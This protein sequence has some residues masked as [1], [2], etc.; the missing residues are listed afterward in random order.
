MNSHIYDSNRP[1]VY[2]SSRG[3]VANARKVVPIW[4]NQ[5][6][7]FDI[8]IAVEP[9]EFYLYA[10]GL[11]ECGINYAEILP[12][13]RPN[14][15]LAYSRKFCVTHAASFGWESIIA[16]DD[17]IKPVHGV[18]NTV[19]DAAHPKA[20]GI[21]IR[22]SYHDLAL[23]DKIRSLGGIILQPNGMFRMVALNV[24]NVMRLGNYDPNA[25]NC[26]DADLMLRGLEAG[27]PWM[28]DLDSKAASIGKRHEPGGSLD[29]IN[30]IGRSIYDHTHKKPILVKK[31]PEIATSNSEGKTRV[32]WLKAHDKYLPDW[33]KWSALHGGD[34]AEYLGI[35]KKTDF[36]EYLNGSPT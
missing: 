10:N 26:E 21:T 17:D 1:K 14:Q 23:G 32:A 16:T 12:L 8:F 3:R 19:M 11:S 36:S 5:G 2:I 31:F 35:T 18:E 9:D 22:Y 7:E 4:H 6:F 34:L 33:R 30:T 24:N 15:G 20:L 27:F 29:Y 28:V 25:D 13:P